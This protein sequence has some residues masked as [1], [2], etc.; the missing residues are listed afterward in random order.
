MTPAEYE[1]EVVINEEEINDVQ[2][3]VV[4]RCSITKTA[5]FAVLKINLKLENYLLLEDDIRNSEFP[6][7]PL[8]I[9]EVDSKIREKSKLGERS[10]HFCTKHYKIIQVHNNEPLRIDSA[11]ISCNLY[12]TNPILH[13]L[14]SNNSFNQI[15]QTTTALDTIKS[16]ESFLT[17]TYGDGAFD[18]K[19]IGEEYQVNKF[20]HE[21]ILTR[22]TNDLIVPMTLIQ[23]YKPFNTFSFYFF[24][25]FR[26]DQDSKAD[27]TCYLINIGNKDNF[28]RRDIS[29]D[30]Y[31]DVVSQLR[32]ISSYNITDSFNELLQDNASI[33]LEGR[34]INYDSI[35][36][37]GTVDVPSV[38]VE[39]FE[40][41]I[42]TGRTVNAIHS[43]LATQPKDPTE[44]TILY[45]SDDIDSAV[46][47]YKAVSTQL[48]EDIHSI[49]VYQ[50]QQ[51]GFDVFQFGIMYNIQ[52]NNKSSFTFT[53]L[54]IVNIFNRETG[55]API[56]QHNTEVQFINFKADPA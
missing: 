8:K 11:Y 39:T 36:A 43:I 45:A 40:E 5:S 17:S 27:I 28:E 46:G 32:N 31:I 4:Y 55:P 38:T 34:N 7:I 51:C 10:K 1:I 23:N 50:S 29:D 54:S 37:T 24:D 18:I 44:K 19:H 16:F 53:P 33:V 42:V 48:R 41:T 26:L 6:T 21:Q 49:E 15:L 13:Y 2:S 12:L 14:N 35:K 22:N 9:Y 56:L 30:K 25:D 3:F 47:R 20:I 52:L